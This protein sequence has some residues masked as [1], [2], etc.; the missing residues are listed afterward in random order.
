MTHV[1]ETQALTRRFGRHEAV[2]DLSICVPA[3]SIFA[4][5]GPNGA[6]KSTTIKLLMNI[7]APTAGSS[8][9]LGVESSRLG[10]AQFQQIGYVAEDQR[11]PE[12]MTVAQFLNYVRPMYPT[13]DPAF[14]DA[15]RQQ[16]DLPPDRTLRQ[17]SRGMRMK[18]AL[19]AS[20][21]YRPKLLVLDEPFT[22]L[23]PLVR[24]EFIQGILELTA[25]EQ[26]TVFISSHDMDEV[27]RLADSVGIIHEGRLR[28]SETVEA[29][30]AR[31]RQVEV[32]L[33]EETPLPVRL[34]EAWL[35]PEKAGRV[36]RFVDSRYD[37]QATEA[38]LRQVLPA[39]GAME[40]TTLSLREIFLAL[41]RT[42][43]MNSGKE[44]Q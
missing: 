28:E 10:P 11:L 27:E 23:D 8:S 13:W 31:F 36:L 20:L 35:I 40:A 14:C 39:A 4:F 44:Q 41:A 22:G 42:H 7:L 15:L 43:R 21:A 17:L 34:P 12:W 3:G 26:W 38:T 37:A 16:F 32:A 25:Q 6:G 24:D 5:L 19:L 30:Q 1:I 29:L 33:P 18:A 9:V 2:H